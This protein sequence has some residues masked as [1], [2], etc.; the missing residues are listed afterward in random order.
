MWQRCLLH[1]VEQLL[2]D[3]ATSDDSASAGSDYTAGSGTITFAPG[4]TTQN[5]PIAVIS[6]T[7]DEPNETIKVTLSNP[8]N[9]TLN[10]PNGVLTITDDDTAP[11]I[12]ID[13]FVTTNEA[14]L[15]HA[16]TVRLSAY[17]VIQSQ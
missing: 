1:L 2:L 9:V 13:D 5:V 14:A 15:T 17:L 11:S 10:D 12:S 6:D 4:V 3:Y 7:T 16:V 8:V